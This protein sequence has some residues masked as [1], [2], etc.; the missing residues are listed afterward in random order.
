MSA[1]RALQSRQARE[2]GA[3]CGAKRGAKCTRLYRC[4]ST[5][6]TT[7]RAASACTTPCG[8]AVCASQWTRPWMRDP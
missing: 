5:R 7:E 3:E 2:S 8:T 4:G 1:Q 6:W